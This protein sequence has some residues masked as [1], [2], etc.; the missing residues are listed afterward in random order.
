MT[1]GG[2]AK[3]LCQRKK[4]GSGK[5]SK[6]FGSGGVG[7]RGRGTGTRDGVRS[8]CVILVVSNASKKKNN[9]VF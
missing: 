9:V 5:G 6:G 8:L 4:E 7:G 3:G 2:T 1:F